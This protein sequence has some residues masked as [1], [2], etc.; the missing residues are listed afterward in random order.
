MK[1]NE[2]ESKDPA[3]HCENLKREI[4]ALIDHLKRDVERVEEPQFQA[5]CETGAE[6]L[7]GLRKAFEHYAAHNESAWRASA[8]AGRHRGA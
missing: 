6:V 3:V 2:T 8:T 7:G 1:T 5:L 4:G